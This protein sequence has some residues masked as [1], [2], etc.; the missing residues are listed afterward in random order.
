MNCTKHFRRFLAILT[1][2]ACLFGRPVPAH[3]LFGVGDEVF[4]PTMYASQL[5][6]L[7][8][9]TATVTNLAQQLQYAI[10]N[11]TGGGAG[12]WQSNQNLLTN[13]GNLINQQEGLSYTAQGLT[14]RFQ[15]LYPGYNTANTAGVQSPQTTAETTLNTLNG[16]LA[17]A[18]AQAQDFQTEQASLQSL[19]LRNQ[20]AA[21]R[22]QAI[23]VGNEIALAQVQQVQMLRQLVMAMMNSQNV[24]A[25]NQVNSQVQSSLEA[26]ALF[27][28]PPSAGIP[29]IF[30]DAPPPP[31]P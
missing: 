31:Q 16:A 30:H 7:Q 27:S 26:Q 15:Q 9:E 1:A 24:A 2:L 10:K 6:Q 20:T 23:Q 18:Q 21:G 14:Q 11:T 4:D 22:L 13:L 5:Q 3:A 19:E 25:A 28:A 12:V 29:D 17:S 8:Q